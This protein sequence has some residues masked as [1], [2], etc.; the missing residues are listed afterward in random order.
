MRSNRESLSCKTESRQ[1]LVTYILL[2][3]IGSIG[4]EIT[5]LAGCGLLYIKWLA[6]L[7]FS[8]TPL[9]DSEKF[10]CSQSSELNQGSEDEN[11]LLLIMSRWLGLS[12]LLAV[13]CL[14]VLIVCGIKIN[15]AG[16]YVYGNKLV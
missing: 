9:G 4:M 13:S 8:R 3:H 14:Q 5:L 10:C 16:T 15:A 6:L 12:L 11:Y 2:T 1:G 7:Y